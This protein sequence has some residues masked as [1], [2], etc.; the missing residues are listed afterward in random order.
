MQMTKTHFSIFN[1]RNFQF[2]SIHSIS[3]VVYSYRFW[4]TMYV[5]YAYYPR[6]CQG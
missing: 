3:P 5:I 2:Q 4:L 6:D 1:R